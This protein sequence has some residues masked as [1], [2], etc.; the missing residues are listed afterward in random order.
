M[1]PIPPH[2]L[3]GSLAGRIWQRAGRIRV[4]LQSL[5]IRADIRGG[6]VAE[7]PVLFQ[8]LIDDLF[9][10]EGYRGV[11][12]DGRWWRPVQDRIEDDAGGIP[13]ERTLARRHFVEDKP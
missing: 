7:F 6:P 1:G 2:H 13:A 5:Q 9:Q 12:P 4:T 3:A 11:Q 10:L 8:R